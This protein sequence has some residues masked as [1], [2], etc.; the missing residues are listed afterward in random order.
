VSVPSS[1]HPA[2]APS[3]VTEWIPAGDSVAVSAEP[4]ITLS[5]GRSNAL[6]IVAPAPGNATSVSPQSMSSLRMAPI[7]NDLSADLEGFENRTKSTIREETK[8]NRYSAKD[9]VVP[10]P[11]LYT[12]RVREVVQQGLND[13]NDPEIN[14]KSSRNPR[15]PIATFHSEPE[16]GSDHHGRTRNSKQTYLISQV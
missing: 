11:R 5:R 8:V 16:Q 2:D 14:G 10:T 4:V 15:A 12:K 13:E 1:N 6:T 7:D 9:S 3:G